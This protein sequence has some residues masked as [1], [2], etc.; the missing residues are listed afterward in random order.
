MLCMGQWFHETPYN[1][2]ISNA[3][4]LQRKASKGPG[5]SLNILIPV[6]DQTTILSLFREAF[7]DNQPFAYKRVPWG[8]NF[9]IQ[10]DMVRVMIYI[11]DRLDE[12]YRDQ[13]L[14]LVP[15]QMT[16]LVSKCV[17]IKRNQPAYRYWFKYREPIDRQYYQ[18]EF[19]FMRRKDDGS[20]CN[21]PFDEG[22]PFCGKQAHGPAA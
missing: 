18:Y 21:N 15:L 7:A 17:E 12:E 9:Y 10:R 3:F 14:E 20:E 11:L 4:A 5:K 2:I 22:Y 19:E 13:L 16:E 6:P 1:L 8:P